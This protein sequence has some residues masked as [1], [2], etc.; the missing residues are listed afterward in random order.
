MGG[1]DTPLDWC[2]PCMAL[3]QDFLR[4]LSFNFNCL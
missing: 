4:V 1:T 2:G 3:L